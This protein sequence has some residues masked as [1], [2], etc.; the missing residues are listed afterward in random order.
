MHRSGIELINLYWEEVWNNGNLELI[1]EICASSIVRHD[2]NEVTSLT[3]DQQIA[4]VAAQRTRLPFFTHEVLVADEHHVCSVWNMTIREGGERELC[5]IEVFRVEEGRLSHCWNSGYI[6]GLWGRDGAEREAREPAILPSLS[7]IDT[8]WIQDI[9]TSVDKST[10]RVGVLQSVDR[11]GNGTLSETARVV[12]HYNADPEN[13][14]TTLFC[15]FNRSTPEIDAANKRV[16]FYE[17]EINTY[18]FLRDHPDISAP[19]VYFAATNPDTGATNIVLEDLSTRTTPGDQVRGASVEEADA[20]VR[21]LSH[22]HAKF[23]GTEPS[24]W[25]FDRQPRAAMFHDSYRIGAAALKEFLGSAVDACDYELIDRFEQLYLDWVNLP[26]GTKTVLHGDPRVD[27]ILFEAGPSG[28]KAWLIDWG[29][30]GVGSPQFDLAY[31][32]TGSVPVDMRRQHDRRWIAEH[33]AELAKASPAYDLASAEMMFRAQAVAQLAATVP[34]A[35]TVERSAR[36]VEL[37]TTLVQRNCAAVRDW[38]AFGAIR[39][40]STM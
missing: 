37:L 20:V 25:L 3:H 23:L 13:Y 9:L 16:G 15:K 4:R 2:A 1:R 17:R 35:R 30:T 38:D 34:A 14:P 32:L 28:I 8:D 33:A 19:K 18:S 12:L 31:F 40:L 29:M 10:P 26:V 36:G 21:A 6:P 22:L 7:S 11:I 27:N 24:D 39:S 5:G